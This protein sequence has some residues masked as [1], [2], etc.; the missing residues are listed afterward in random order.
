MSAAP[1]PAATPDAISF[2]IQ[3]P[4]AL[5]KQVTL[6][7]PTE[8]DLSDNGVSKGRIAASPGMRLTVVKIEPGY[9]TV[10][11][12]TATKR[13]PIASTNLTA[14]APLAMQNYLNHG[15]SNASMMASSGT[16]ASAATS[17][18]KATS[19]AAAY[20][21]D[22]DALPVK[23]LATVTDGFTHPGIGITKEMLQNAAAQ[24]KAKREPW[25]TG[26][27]R[28]A[29][30]PDS[31]E[32]VSCRNQSKTDPSKP[33]SDTLDSRGMV[34]RL[35]G[36]GQ[37]AYH[38]ALMYCFTGKE[39]YRA[40]AMNIIRIWSKLDPKKV[41]A[42]P[43]CYIHASGPVYTMIQAGELMRYTGATRGDLAWTDRD[44][45]AFSKNF[46]VPC[47]VNFFDTNVHFMNQDGYPKMAT[48]AGDIFTNNLGDYD[49]RV[50]MFTVN[51]GAENQ[52]F[53]FSIKRLARLVN[54]DDES[55]HPVAQPQVQL[56]EMG[57]DQAHAG[58]DVEIFMNIVRMLNAQGTKV[59]PA[60]G[61]VSTGPDAVGAYEFLD[62]RIL[63]ASDFFFRFMLGYDT[64]WIPA[65]YDISKDGRVH[66]IYPRIADNYRGRIQQF[67]YWDAYYYYTCIRG[68]DLAQKAPYLNEAFLKRITEPD[69]DWIYVP[70]NLSGPAAKPMANS[71]QAGALD[72]DRQSTPLDHNASVVKEGPAAFLRVKPTPDGARVA[73]L[74][75]DTEQ[76]TLTLRARTN[77]VAEIT[78]AGFKKPW[79]LPDT[80]G[81]WRLVPYT[82]DAL[83]RLGNI[84]FC[85]VKGAAD[86][87][88]DLDYLN[89][90]GGGN[91]TAPAFTMGSDEVRLI[92]CVGL[93]VKLDL[94]AKGGGSVQIG[95]SSLPADAALGSAG[96]FQ[97]TPR[98]PGENEFVITAA[99]G[100]VI[101]T[102]KIRIKVM[103]SRSDAIREI[104]AAYDPKAA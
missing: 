23:V 43:E 79:L 14:L 24:L 65:A 44:T 59:N 17:V 58:D 57:R 33:D 52:G 104:T 27:E 97:W 67:E 13:L 76:K 99:E 36:D 34:A 103:A 9:L 53:C 19:Y 45:E 61:T 73:I 54:K 84:V 35:A 37:K 42:F 83:E 87:Q 1:V 85:T 39:K 96:A 86:S 32:S 60:N 98:Q 21:A 15:D 7:A 51:R 47:L 101:T 74:G 93:P 89:V 102:K 6:L 64:P 75:G 2:L 4:A 28:M 5:P 72:L 71:R 90:R 91:Q 95:S 8:F 20:A 77:G 92:T 25:V 81:E 40:N 55:G 31:A 62:D 78:M 30:S 26:F 80:K 11:L 46:V 63:A 49:K 94:S 3:N 22:S 41:R 10:S 18:T 56:M 70:K 50:E 88:A 38:Q 69:T 12:G 29:A 100:D 66:A 48:I 68:V 16:P 82:M